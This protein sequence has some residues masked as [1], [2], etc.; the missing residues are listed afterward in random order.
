[1]ARRQEQTSGP[2]PSLSG[3]SHHHLICLGEIIEWKSV[4]SP[5]LWFYLGI[6]IINP[7]AESRGLQ[8]IPEQMGIL[9]AQKWTWRGSAEMTLW[10]KDGSREQRLPALCNHP[11]GILA[12]RGNP[13]PRDELSRNF[14]SEHSGAGLCWALGILSGWQGVGSCSQCPALL[15]CEINWTS[16][17]RAGGGAAQLCLLRQSWGSC[18]QRD[19]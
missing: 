1:M 8:N 12:W 11:G 16:D 4:S 13:G 6:Q 18:P 19:S 10:G 15:A 5:A 3:I 9:L 7:W 2:L 14:S 17:G